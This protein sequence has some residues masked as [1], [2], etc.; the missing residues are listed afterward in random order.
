V[1]RMVLMGE[2]MLEAAPAKLWNMGVAVWQ[3][4]WPMILINR[5]LTMHDQDVTNKHAELK[6]AQF[7]VEQALERNDPDGV[8]DGYA[9]LLKIYKDA[10]IDIGEYFSGE[11]SLAKALELLT[12]S[13]SEAPVPSRPN[14][15]FMVLV[16][17]LG[18]FIVNTLA[19]P[20]SIL[21]FGEHSGW[22][23]RMIEGWGESLGFFG[24]VYVAQQAVNYVWAPM[25]EWL[26]KHRPDWLTK[27]KAKSCKEILGQTPSS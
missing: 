17:L 15:K 5:A 16:T 4:M 20:S 14:E 1:V 3:Y 10:K 2:P 19:Q 18:A 24:G 7:R 8:A 9:R 25:T 21:S 13:R 27:R 12:Q 11:F 26:Q 6:D 22:T 23:M